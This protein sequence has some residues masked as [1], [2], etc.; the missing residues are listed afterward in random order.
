MTEFIIVCTIIGFFS[1]FSGI[2][3][4]EA[5]NKRLYEKCKI[6]FQDKPYKEAIEI[7]KERVK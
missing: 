3:S 6:E 5:E 7:C 4:T 1:F 2:V